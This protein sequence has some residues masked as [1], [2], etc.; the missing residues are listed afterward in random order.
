MH[1]PYRRSWEL[2]LGL[3]TNPIR[4]E[5]IDSLNFS[6]YELFFY[7]NKKLKMCFRSNFVLLII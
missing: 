3:R 2:Y 6:L 5:N 1:A 4:P 7:V